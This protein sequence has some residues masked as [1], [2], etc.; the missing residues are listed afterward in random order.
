MG[1]MKFVSKILPS[2]LLKI[3]GLVSGLLY[4]VKSFSQY[5]EDLV[6]ENFIKQRGIKSGVY[7]DI[8]GFH[9]VW[10]SNTKRLHDAGWSGHVVDIDPWKLWA[11]RLIRGRRCQTHLGAVG[12]DVSRHGKPVKVFRFKRMLSEIDTLSL[13]D[14]TKY[15]DEWGYEFRED[16]VPFLDISVLV[17]EV[18]KV[19]VINIDIEGLDQLVLRAIDLRKLAPVIVVFEDNDCWGGSRETR[20]FLESNGY[21]RLFV[22]GGSVGYARKDLTELPTWSEA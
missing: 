7:L 1:K 10:I 2:W 12:S 5:G 18:G 11:F 6:V 13:S 16:T 22:T 3:M 14:A 15:R 4:R 19:D 9:P 20:A 21:E 8:G 17:R